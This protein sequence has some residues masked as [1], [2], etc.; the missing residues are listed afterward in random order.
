MVDWKAAPLTNEKKML[1][2]STAVSI[3]H[4]A[5]N[6]AKGL[7]SKLV[8]QEMFVFR[9]IWRALFS[10]NTLFEIALL[11][12]CRPYDVLLKPNVWNSSVTNSPYPTGINTHACNN[13]NFKTLKLLQIV[14]WHVQIDHPK[15]FFLL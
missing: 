3:P 6:K 1:A 2:Y 10:C 5:G 8:L 7:I 13:V 11:P 9:K 4:N 14:T 12:H 15:Q